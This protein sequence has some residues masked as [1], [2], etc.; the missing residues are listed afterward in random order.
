MAPSTITSDVCV[1]INNQLY[2]LRDLQSY[3]AS[4]PATDRY[5]EQLAVA[6]QLMHLDNTMPNEIENY[7][8]YVRTDSAWTEVITEQKFQTDWADIGKTIKTRQRDRLAEAKSTIVRYW[9]NSVAHYIDSS[10][11]HTASAMRK[12][13]RAQQD[14]TATKIT[15]NAIVVRRIQQISSRS[16]NRIELQAIDFENAA[17]SIA[18][19]PVQPEELDRLNLCINS[20]GWLERAPEPIIDD[21]AGSVTHT[22]IYLIILLTSWFSARCTPFF[23]TSDSD[24]D[25]LS[26][27]DSDNAGSDRDSDHSKGV[28][29]PSKSTKITITPCHCLS[30]V[31]RNWQAKVADTKL[32]SM[33]DVM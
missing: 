30:T 15:L 17:K 27:V 21:A 13:T 18:I 7:C 32:T 24:N 11:Y 20:Q 6:K 3:F 16:S 33:I 23:S 25:A 5:P 8:D 14:L 31:S 22:P 29:K 19:V 2:R 9:D 28:R 10:T 12:Y 26:S 1:H 4:L